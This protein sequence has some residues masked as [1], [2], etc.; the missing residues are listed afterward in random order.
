MLISSWPRRDCNISSDFRPRTVADLRILENSPVGMALEESGMALEEKGADE[1]RLG[2][3][4]CLSSP[5]RRARSQP[6]AD[7]CNASEFSKRFLRL[8][9]LRCCRRGRSRKQFT[10]PASFTGTRGRRAL[11]DSSK[12]VDQGGLLGDAWRA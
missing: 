5:S 3:T 12:P 7:G 2:H 10:T 8:I 4:E 9:T 6:L 1:A 11:F